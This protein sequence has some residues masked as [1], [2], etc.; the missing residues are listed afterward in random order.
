MVEVAK[1]LGKGLNYWDPSTAE[2][3]PDEYLGL[4]EE[5]KETEA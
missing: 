4:V 5:P 3:W 1:Y 2:Q